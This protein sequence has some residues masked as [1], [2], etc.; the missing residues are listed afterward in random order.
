[1][2]VEEF[3]E[4]VLNGYN[5]D[6]INITDKSSKINTELLSF[7]L[8][9]E[10]EGTYENTHNNLEIKM[11][12]YY[13]EIKIESINTEMLSMGKKRNMR[14]LTGTLFFQTTCRS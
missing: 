8:G 10:K 2:T 12:K 13:D 14:Q 7:F 11:Q 6:F 9:A 4:K 1:M 5:V 3:M